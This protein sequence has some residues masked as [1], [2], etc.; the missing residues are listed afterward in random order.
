MD[1]LTPT[2]TAAITFPSRDLA[3]TFAKLWSRRTLTGHDMSPT[4][5]DG[6][7]ALKIYHV[8]PELKM[9]IS[10]TIKTLS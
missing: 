9:W 5:A 3:Q 4:Q 10:E 6:K 2:E 8:T 1:T 7:T